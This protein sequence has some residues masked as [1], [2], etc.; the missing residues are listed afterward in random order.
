MDD[1]KHSGDITPLTEAA[2][3]EAIEADLWTVT[4]HLDNTERWMVVKGATN[5]VAVES[6]PAILD[7]FARFRQR[8]SNH[9][10][11]LDQARAEVKAS[12]ESANG[13]YFTIDTFQ[14]I[15]RK[16]GG[17][18]TNFSIYDLLSDRKPTVAPRKKQTDEET[19]QEVIEKVWA[20][21]DRAHDFM[22]GK[23]S[24][25][26]W[27][28]LTTLS[29]MLREG[30]PAT[31]SD[32]IRIKKPILKP[33]GPAVNY[34]GNLIVP[35]TNVLAT[36]LPDNFKWSG[37]QDI[38]PTD[39]PAK[40]EKTFQKGQPVV[41]QFYPIG[42]WRDADLVIVCEGMAT[43]EALYQASNLPV[44]CALGLHNI[45]NVAV[46]L[47]HWDTVNCCRRILIAADSGHDAEMK[48]F[49]R[50]LRAEYGI[51]AAGWMVPNE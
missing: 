35:M 33:A 28:R 51:N 48:K 18:V 37:W 5:Q 49:V 34:H 8:N 15:V 2:I 1:I 39:D 27:N 3:I 23:Q 36:K 6:H 40:K 10:I 24:G 13:E 47:M 29:R 42:E 45:L 41:G 12:Y 30:T 25:A 26:S 32:Y 46:S 17:T 22:Q 50:V 4:Q 21:S 9:P 14:Y 44:A 16:K 31:E 43:G 7:I 38:L 20:A 11:S 19:C